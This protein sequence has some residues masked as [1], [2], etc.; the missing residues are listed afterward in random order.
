MRDYQ[1]P[2]LIYFN[3]FNKLKFHYHKSSCHILPQNKRLQ[4]QTGYCFYNYCRSFLP[5]QFTLKFL[6]RVFEMLSCH[7]KSIASVWL[8]GVQYQ[9]RVKNLTTLNTIVIKKPA[10]SGLRVVSRVIFKGLD[11]V[12]EG[13]NECNKRQPV[14]C[15]LTPVARTD[16]PLTSNSTR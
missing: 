14:D 15:C 3:F 12:G 13:G 7:S 8:A 16:M 11:S 4:L 10:E 5:F 6:L 1:Y 2:Q 9:K